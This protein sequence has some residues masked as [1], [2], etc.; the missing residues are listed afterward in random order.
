MVCARSTVLCEAEIVCAWFEFWSTVA[1]VLL[2]THTHILAKT[3]NPTPTILFKLIIYNQDNITKFGRNVHR[4]MAH[5]IVK[6][7]L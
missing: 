2:Y 6:E 3:A 1:I 7:I 4:Y 5:K